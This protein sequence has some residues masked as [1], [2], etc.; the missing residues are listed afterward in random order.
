MRGVDIK[1]TVTAQMAHVAYVLGKCRLNG[2]GNKM[3]G[4]FEC[5]CVRVVTEKFRQMYHQK[6][7]L[8]QLIRTKTG[9]VCVN[10]VRYCRPI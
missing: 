3:C 2:L 9:L 4:L 5:G 8:S 6:T 7:N 1:F 10:I